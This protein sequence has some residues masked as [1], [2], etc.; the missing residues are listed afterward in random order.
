MTVRNV[1]WELRRKTSEGVAAAA[2]GVEPEALKPKERVAIPRVK[3]PELDAEY[4]AKTRLEEV[5][6]GLTPRDG[7]ARGK[8]MS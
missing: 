1:L 6:I 3:M 5:N 2:N 4:R 8:E 7:Y